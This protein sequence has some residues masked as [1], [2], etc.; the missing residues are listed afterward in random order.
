MRNT[1]K[2]RRTGHGGS[3]A[4][5]KIIRMILRLTTLERI[6]S[7]PRIDIQVGDGN[8]GVETWQTSKTGH[9]HAL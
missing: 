2:C 7:F 4:N 5:M 8:M 3:R 6:I 9:M 1:R